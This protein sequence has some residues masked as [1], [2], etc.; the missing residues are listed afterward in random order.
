MVVEAV[1]L[2]R[3]GLRVGFT[4]GFR[5]L[6]GGIDPL[7]A[8]LVGTHVVDSVKTLNPKN[9][10]DRLAI[11]NLSCNNIHVPVKKSVL[12]TMFSIKKLCNDIR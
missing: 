6:L 4:G 7:V 11:N 10:F 9:H 12:M 2:V 1:V 3:H 5:F 8:F